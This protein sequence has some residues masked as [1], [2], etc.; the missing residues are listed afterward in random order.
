MNQGHSKHEMWMRLCDLCAKHPEEVTGVLK[1]S[2]WHKLL[3]LL[4]LKL[5]ILTLVSS[6]SCKFSEIVL[7]VE[8]RADSSTQ[9]I[10]LLEDEAGFCCCGVQ[11]PG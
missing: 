2:S 3:L 1:V 8:C 5:R 9:A 7:Y 10:S 4:K 11:F 6:P